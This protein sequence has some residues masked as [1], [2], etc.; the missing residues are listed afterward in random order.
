MRVYRHSEEPRK[1]ARTRFSRKLT[2]AQAQA[3]VRGSPTDTATPNVNIVLRVL[4][5]RAAQL[6]GTEIFDI[7]RRLSGDISIIIHRLEGLSSAFTAADGILYHQRTES[8][9]YLTVGPVAMRPS[10]LI[11]CPDAPSAG[12]LG[13]QSNLARVKKRFWWS[14]MH[15]DVYLEVPSCTS[16]QARKL[17]T[18]PQPMLLQPIAP[19]N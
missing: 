13:Q 11:I 2:Q 15:A 17:V 14:G 12:H 19:P 18:N 10:V 7:V 3:I 16:R 6:T 8:E 5:F 9:S 1:A 4:D